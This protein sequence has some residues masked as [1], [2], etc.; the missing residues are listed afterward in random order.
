MWWP[1][2]AWCWVAFRHNDLGSLCVKIR[3]ALERV[4]SWIIRF[5]FSIA[6][7]RVTGNKPRHMLFQIC[8]TFLDDAIQNDQRDLT[9]TRDTLS[10]CN[11]SESNVTSTHSKSA[12]SLRSSSKT[13]VIKAW[14]VFYLYILL[15][16]VLLYNSLSL[17]IWNMNIVLHRS[18]II[19]VKFSIRGATWIWI[20][21]MV[22]SL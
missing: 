7:Q 9:K 21:W 2:P 13:C 12:P 8:G 14:L 15:Y 22:L 10:V 11:I 16:V 18:Y 5:A 20:S 19:S 6:C 3:P 4:I 17:P 1:G